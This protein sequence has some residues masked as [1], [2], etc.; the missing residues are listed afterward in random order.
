MFSA[1]FRSGIFRM[2]IRFSLL[3]K[4][5]GADVK[6]LRVYGPAGPL[7]TITECGRTFSSPEGIHVTVIGGPEEQWI[8][9]AQ[10]DT[11]VV[12][13]GADYML[14]QLTLKFRNAVTTNQRR[15]Q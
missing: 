1:T 6:N 10:K 9:Q 11:D 15:S 12:F 3:V 14:T 2:A 8:T 5:D 4:S 7:N 13:A